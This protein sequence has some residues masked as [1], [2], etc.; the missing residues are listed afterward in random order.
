MRFP[1]YIGG[2]ERTVHE[3]A[4]RLAARGH[5]IRVVCA[6]EPAGLPPRA[7]LDG[8]EVER[9][10]Y[11]G[12]IGNTNLCP[13][14]PGA[15]RA[16]AA[17]VVHAHLP[18]AGFADA[19]AGASAALRAPLVLTYNNDL[20]GR[21][22]KGVLAAVY[23]RLLL[24]RLLA[25]ATRV[26]VPNPDYT[27]HSSWLAAAADKLQAIPWG[28][29]VERL[30]P[31]PPPGAADLVVGFLSLLDVHHRYKGLEVL[32]RALALLPGARLRV[33]G[34][35]VESE[36]YR[37]LAAEL[38]LAARVDFLG[39]VPEA[40]LQSF[41]AACDLFALP[42]TDARQEGFGL[43]LLEAMACGRPVLTTPVAGVATAVAAAGAGWVVPAGDVEA[44]AAALRA[45]GD[46]GQRALAAMGQRARRLVEERYTWEGCADAYEAL[47]LSLSSSSSKATSLAGSSQQQKRS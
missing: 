25:R 46:A 33:G 12:K 11:F 28:V 24:P 27:R 26:V 15:L 29:D 41:Y 1:P 4:K 9:L 38:G 47:F 21:G 17:D 32:L 2:V 16:R 6:A 40:A 43:V 3:L 10:P 37:R 34:T 35:G 45:A 30:R 13:G 44:T 23:N 22:A 36:R 5:E 39:L 31:A 14:L 19:A 7:R 42:S 8:V 18:T 20:T